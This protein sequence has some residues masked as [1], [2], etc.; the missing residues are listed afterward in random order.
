MSFSTGAL[1]FDAVRALFGRYVASPAGRARLEEVFPSADREEAERSLAE[2][3]ESLA[4]HEAALQPPAA[5]RNSLVR[6]RFDGLPDVRPHL[7]KLAIPG[8]VLEGMELRE[9]ISLLDRAADIRSQLASAGARFPLIAAHASRIADHRPLLRDLAGKIEPDGGVAD[10]ASVALN[11]LRRDI[12]RQQRAIQESLERFMRAHRGDGVLQEE[13]VTFRN[14]R[15]VLPIVAGQKRR[16]DGIVH[17]AS[18]TGHTLFIEPLETVGL[19]NDLVRLREQESR[20]VH[21]ILEEMTE[22]VRQV[23]GD[24]RETDGILGRL[25]LLFAKARFAADFDCVVPSFSPPAA[26]RLALAG[27]RHPLLVDVLR[28]QRKSVVP[29][30]LTLEGSTRTLL[31]SG[32]NTGGKTVTLK[33]VGIFALMAQSGLPVPATEAVLPFFDRVLADIGDHQSLEQSLSTFSAHITRIR[34]MLGEVGP[35]SL[36]LLDELGRATDPEEGGA[37]GVAI[38]DHVRR[39]GAYTLASTHLL[40]PK[41]YGS[42]TEGV[43]NASMSFDEETLAPTYV[44]KTGV[45]GASAGLDIA[46]RIG[47]PA[48][49]IEQARGSLSSGQ[50]NLSR[51]LRLLE[52][53]LESVS[54]LE[55]ELEERKRA[56][57]AEQ[58]GL[59]DFWEKRESARLAELDRRVEALLARFESQARLTLEQIAHSGDQRKAAEHASRKVAQVKRELREEMNAAAKS[60]PEAGA[61]AAAAGLREGLRVKLRGVREPARIRRLLGSGAIEV[62]AGFLKLQVGREEVLEILPEAP[63]EARLPKGISLRT[64]PRTEAVSQ[65]INVIGKRAEEALDEV[66][67]FLDTAA[68]ASVSRV[69]IVHG[70]GMGVLKRAIGELLESHALVL[71]HYP[72]PAQEGGAGATIAELRTG[73]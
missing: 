65:E 41:I 23:A 36:V 51:L 37:L 66:D 14:D 9:L 15:Y 59:K 57:E 58:A 20:E 18:G 67:K 30:T 38:V 24:I 19:N 52:E 50:R 17:A 6:I 28:R 43:L 32:P 27:A 33:T 35:R 34:E 48:E 1:E 62:E 53:K 71:K 12:E 21:R 22:R 68:L 56:M 64:A 5:G 42:A 61:A 39:T 47:L 70:H 10:H 69:R 54:R 16:V 45:P 8:V 49:L 46:Q 29:L 25:E 26:P 60:Q 72:A 7:A 2:A 31:I 40:A 73:E 13:F 3:A 44:L 11:R 55:R 63:E 4:Y